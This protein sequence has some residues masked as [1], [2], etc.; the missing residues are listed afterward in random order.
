MIRQPVAVSQPFAYRPGKTILHRTPA[1]LKLL[2]V[3]IISIAACVSVY[4]LA[5]SILLVFVF[6]CTARIRPW[7]LLRGSKPLAVISLCILIMKTIDPGSPGVTT[8]EIIIFNLYIPDLHIPGVSPAGF[9]DG[10]MAVLRVFTPFCAAA[11]FFAVTS[12]RELRLSIKKVSGTYFSLGISLML[13][14]IPRFF[15]L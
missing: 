2:C 4:S 12:M 11:L 9:F 8:P 10:V 1:V 15:S 5:A 7:E 3:I 13:G 14:F 6:S